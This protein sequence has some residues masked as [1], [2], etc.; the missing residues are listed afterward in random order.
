MPE[1]ERPADGLS[2]VAL[3]SGIGALLL[4]LFSVVP[5]AGWCFMPLSAVA[6]LTSLVTSIA[7]LVRTTLNPKLEG[8]M[9][10]L[11]ALL[12]VLLWGAGAGLLAMFV[13]RH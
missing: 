6:A 4:V 11:A 1:A 12:F 8:R 13:S 2:I 5:L 3:A 9:Q 7:S 10:A